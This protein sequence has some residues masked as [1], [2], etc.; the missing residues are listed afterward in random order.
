MPT[1]FLDSNVIVKYLRGD[2]ASARLF[3][4]RVRSRVRLAINPI[5]L[6]ELFAIAEVRRRPKLLGTL[7]KKLT[8]L[9]IDFARSAQMLTRVSGFRNQIAHSNDLLIF[10]SAAD[11]DYLV[12]YDYDF[13]T[14]PTEGRPKVVTPEQL[15]EELEISA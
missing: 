13:A 7:Q 2:G 14:I 12:T 3:D 8:V 1:A 9:P 10:G 4:R 5:V 6:Q 11:C 15:L